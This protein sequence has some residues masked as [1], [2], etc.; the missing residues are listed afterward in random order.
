MKDIDKKKRAIGTEARIKNTSKLLQLAKDSPAKTILLGLAT[1]L[2][3]KNILSPST[4]PSV[5]TAETPVHPHSSAPLP[6][7]EV[8]QAERP[9]L[10]MPAGN[11]D[12]LKSIFV[13]P[14][15]QHGLP[16][17]T[18]AGA[19]SL[20]AN[21]VRSPM[22]VQTVPT[23]PTVEPA[24]V[25]VND[26]ID[27][28]GATTI[29][30]AGD[31][32]AWM[33]PMARPLD[34][35][36]MDSTLTDTA[37][38]LLGLLLGG[39]NGLTDASAALLSS[40]AVV[41]GHIVDAMVY[42]VDASGKQIGNYV[43]TD[44]N[45]NYSGLTAGDA[46]TKIVVK[47]LANYVDP[48]T[49]LT[50][51]SYDKDLSP[52]NK[53]AFTS[54]LTLYA[55]G[56]ATVV[57]PITTLIQ[58][59][60]DQDPTLSLDSATKWVTDSLGLPSTI[61]YLSFDPLNTPSTV[62]AA[63]AL[64]VQKIASQ[65]A[66]L[67]TSASS[68]ASA[69]AADFGATSQQVM[70][71]LASALRTYA[72]SASYDS[73]KSLLTNGDALVS[74]F[75]GSALAS[76]N[77]NSALS[78]S[79]QLN[80]QI[81][82]SDSIDKVFATQ[83]IMQSMAVLGP[84]SGDT[85]AKVMDVFTASYT[86]QATPNTPLT[87]TNAAAD[88]STAGDLV[89]AS[90]ATS[91]WTYDLSSAVGTYG[92]FAV[93]KS[94]H[95][96]FSANGAHNELTQGQVVSQT[97][98]VTDVSAKTYTTLTVNITG[99]NDAA[100]LSSQ[101]QTVT[102]GNATADLNTSGQLT[103]KDVDAGE[104]V[105][106]AKD[107]AGTYGTF[108]VNADGSWTY[109]G[110]GPHNELT[111][112][113]QVSDSVTV[114]SKDGTASGTITVNITGTNDAAVF[115][116]DLSSDLLETN[117]V[118][119]TSGS[120][121][122]TDADGVANAFKAET[123]SGRYG[124]LV[125]GTNG[126]WSYVSSSAQDALAAGVKAVDTFT[127]HAA[128]GTPGT[129]TVTITGT[130]DPASVSSQI[131]AVTEG[132]T[133][134]DLNAFG[135]LT[136]QDP[137]T[138]EAVVVAKDAA[139]S[140]GNFHVNADG[141][142]TYTGNGPHNELTAGQVVSDSVTVY[143]KDGT[144]SGI[145]TVNITGTN[146]AAIVSSQS[147]AVNE[148]NAAADLNTSG[149]LLI[150]DADAG[151]AVVVAKDYAGTYGSFHVHADGSWTYT[152]NG[153]H[154]ELTAGQQVSDSVTVSSKDGT[155]SGTITVN[156]TGTNDAAVFNGNRTIDLVETNSVLSTSGQLTSTDV[157]GVANVFLAETVLGTF[158]SLTMGAD[159]A[160]SYASSNE[161]NQLVAG[162]KAVDTFTVH[163]ADGTPTTLVVTITGT[164]DA[165]MVSSQTQ[166]VTEGNTAS[167]LNTSGQLSITDLDAGEA[168][169]VATDY[170]GKYGSFHVNADGSWTYTGNGSHNELTAGQQVSDS[171]TVYSKDGT[172]S[173][174]II[175]NITGSNDVA[176]VS[177]A[178]QAV[179][180]GDTAAA[181]NTFGKLDIRD[182]DTGEAHVVAQSV[183]GTYGTIAVD[184]DGNWTFTANGA[185]NEL[186]AGQQVSQS[187]TVDSQDG[188]GHG[189]ITV[190]ITGT[191]DVATV[192]SATAAVEKIGN[193][194]VYASGLL[195]VTDADAGQ[196][197]V[198]A[199]DVQATYGTFHVT[200]DGQWTYTG[201]TESLTPGTQ[202]SDSVTVS[203]KD[204]TGHG[205]ITVNITATDAQIAI[206]PDT[207]TVYESNLVTSL[208]T[209]GQLKISAINPAYTTLAAQND[210]IGT[211]GTFH[212][213]TDGSWT[214]T[215]NG[216]HNEL[217]AGQRVSDSVTVS[218]SIVNSIKGTITVNIVGTNDAAT[219]SSQSQAV[220]E[221]ND[222]GAL[223]TSGQLTIT[224]PD[225]GEAHVVAQSVAGT[226][227]TLAVDANGAWTFTPNGA[228]NELT[229]GQQVSQSLTVM[230]QD[231]TASG[232]ITVNI[233]GTNDVAT[234]SSQSV[235]KTEG[236][237][238]SALS[239][240]GKLDIA[241]A[242]AGQAHVVAQSVAGTYGTI[243]VD[244]DGNW[245][246]T[247]NGA[248]NE[249]TA[250]QQ[251]SQSL[252]VMSQDGSAS[253]TITV[254]ITGT[255]DAAT[256]SSQSS[257]VTEGDTTSALN[258]SGKLSIADADTGQ[259]HVVAQSV[260]GTYGTIAVD[261][262]GNW[263]F[264]ANGAHNELTAGQKVSQSLV[265]TSQD[266][267]A[268]STITVN[269]TG[270]NDVATVSSQTNAVTEGNTP[271]VLNT[272]GKLTVS[273]ADTGEAHVVAQ[274][275]AGTYGTIA[276]DANGNW[277]FVANDAHNELTAGQ[278]V[279]QSLTVM[280]QDGSASGTITVNITGTNDVPQIT[281]NVSSD[282]KIHLTYL[283][284][285]A[286]PVSASGLLD[287]FELKATDLDGSQQDINYRFGTAANLADHSSYF[288]IDHVNDHFY[289]AVTRV[290]AE[291]IAASGGA[292]SLNFN[293]LATD[294]WMR[295]FFSS[296][297]PYASQQLVDITYQKAVS[298][299]GTSATLPGNLS[300]WAITPLGTVD[301]QSNPIG[302]GFSAISLLD[303]S[304]VINLP[305]TVTQ[306]HFGDS[307]NLSVSNLSTAVGADGNIYASIT[308]TS[309]S[310]Q[311]ITIEDTAVS[312]QIHMASAGA[313]TVVGAP[314]VFGDP[315]LGYVEDLRSD[316]VYLQDAN[317]AD[318]SFTIVSGDLP[319]VGYKDGFHTKAEIY[320]DATH[321]TQIG[322]L[323]IDDVEY[324]QF[325]DKKIRLIGDDIPRNS[326][327]V[328]DID[329]N[330]DYVII[331][332]PDKVNGVDNAR[333]DT[334]SVTV[335][336]N[337][338]PIAD[339]ATTSDGNVQMV[340]RDSV[341][342]AVT[343]TSLLREIETV[344]FVYKDAL[345]N[346]TVLE[347][348]MIVAGGGYADLSQIS[349]STLSASSTYL[350]N[351]SSSH[352]N[353]VYHY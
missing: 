193:L 36:T 117:D 287:L 341:T 9:N 232:T 320:S 241:D 324:V 298:A 113:Q 99:T 203:S 23:R 271:S 161:Q 258:T 305:N 170:A 187:L 267:T 116:G 126:A 153:A 84:I 309:T 83:V 276:V 188:T 31:D 181:L 2:F 259:A 98:K 28:D 185:H 15:Q 24:T 252:T 205:T 208:N 172:A 70:T 121:T 136:I 29:Q 263:T 255:N 59:L 12:D 110:N 152:G 160:W 175:V 224:D 304:I 14:S 186:T 225:T 277:T 222:L 52:G 168:V 134:T 90:V 114:S 19:V 159:G 45:G 62:K 311:T 274:S 71:Q 302:N 191:N 326:D 253:G 147:Q 139:G 22:V 254:N 299:D 32:R 79:A 345:G 174:T 207:V 192:T 30:V 171:I 120:L 119:K 100:T 346:A 96:T 279:S 162:E 216:P 273:D 231:G 7:V 338:M 65:V 337:A 77:L 82:G 236:D 211:Y 295:E 17:A 93:S 47:A 335:H 327:T 91:D 173:G 325:K 60:K 296:V 155:A 350:Y 140:Y 265:V 196:A 282:G 342:H 331:G 163:A 179:T 239:T 214:Y 44:V 4:S 104:A 85:V 34:V 328:I 13:A 132:N 204:G 145:I 42:R 198:V 317:Y 53:I 51:N 78:A 6:D 269:I 347:N 293:L 268:S 244:A 351:P 141:S 334:V 81:L 297:S 73:Q 177:S 88:L 72:S 202:V 75:K 201:N 340:L 251:V 18:V 16:D 290:G 286:V 300:D 243:A 89:S 137:D 87:E 151:E 284:G 248:H 176:T 318:A 223:S 301:A 154:N 219:V 294:A 272:S 102:E 319:F 64:A 103:I 344:Q 314:D 8:S 289:L 76:A 54:A 38:G 131:K 230:S 80:Q 143:S 250:G 86:Q 308:D 329:A 108:H 217:T 135:Q 343:G 58:S 242:D 332:S 226:Y 228:H 260:A 150:S 61:S 124:S 46:T 227:G 321:K 184:A 281:S 105:V 169:V 209:A 262:D 316:T 118:L 323:T 146:D 353:D 43:F 264:T 25:A 215:A 195:Q 67:V 257:A 303:P 148:G 288:Q 200:S 125:I 26:A 306:L 349:Q 129:V 322:T 240:S 94:G 220:T 20:N 107:Y 238:P 278:Q 246:F 245:T 37:L 41:D 182:A 21:I 158:G 97:L 144:A 166:A 66:L 106:T 275:V 40:G 285:T 49:G 212:V 270:T 213:N 1:G 339:F 3:F 183:A 235:S 190:N 233:T 27:Q 109:I 127:I 95:W 128:D 68:S 167:A 333:K 197:S 237:T 234:V 149:Q 69:S 164:N 194:P 221:G 142:W 111:A 92:T 123:V 56:N 35:L 310:A 206:N 249:L 352:L 133:A 157:D 199:Q 55:P 280:S 348:V 48:L 57:N 50:H 218:S 307:S 130:N 256:V 178:T 283:E 156:I 112:G 291:N 261:A 336:Q 210:Y 11:A 63:D 247:A 74:A 292:D 229:A 10:L 330:G 101:T 122:A 313:H 138:G 180:E 115:A 39:G 189:T 33:D 312:T 266:G 5:D 165:A 315:G